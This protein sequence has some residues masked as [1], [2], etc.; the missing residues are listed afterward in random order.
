MPLIF[1]K[2]LSKVKCKPLHTKQGSR[3][4]PHAMRDKPAAEISTIPQPTYSVTAVHD[5]LERE[6][7]LWRQVDTHHFS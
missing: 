5:S 1:I 2:V 6:K 3:R 4:V 7:S